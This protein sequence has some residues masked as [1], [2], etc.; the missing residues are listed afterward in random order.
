[1]AAAAVA[2][3]EAVLA[4]AVDSVENACI[5]LG[6]ALLSVLPKGPSRSHQHECMSGKVCA[7]CCSAQPARASRHAA[8]VP[9]VHRQQQQQQRRVV[10]S[11]NS[12]GSRPPLH[13]SSDR[14]RALLL[15]CRWPSSRAPMRA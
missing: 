8:A 6:S 4:G 7:L 2:V 10:A 12:S 14:S 5:N 9:P 15:C 11:S 13:A 3:G 1:M